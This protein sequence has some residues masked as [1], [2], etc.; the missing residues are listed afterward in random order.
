MYKDIL[1]LFRSEPELERQLP[2]APAARWSPIPDAILHDHG[3][4]PALPR[5]RQMG[6]EGEDKC[7]ALTN[8]MRRPEVGWGARADKRLQSI[9]PYLDR[10]SSFQYHAIS[11]CSASHSL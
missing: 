9:H 8:L 6:D 7:M 10:L 4:S 2:L 11:P 1:L 5:W 3:Q